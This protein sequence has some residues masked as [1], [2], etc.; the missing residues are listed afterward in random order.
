MYEV[1]IDGKRKV[2]PVKNE[3]PHSFSSAKIYAGDR[4]SPPAHANIRNL[5]V[6]DCGPLQGSF[7]LIMRIKCI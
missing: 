6:G 4:Y 7:Y 5:I 2:G 1:F 3:K